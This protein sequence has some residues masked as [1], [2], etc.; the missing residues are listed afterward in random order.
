MPQR[1]HAMLQ[2]LVR[3]LGVAVT[4][5][6][7]HAAQMR[8]WVSDVVSADRAEGQG[9]A[10]ARVAR[11]LGIT[12][13]RVAEILYGRVGRVW[14]DEYDRA[15]DWHARWCAL[16]AERLAHE[17]TIYRARADALRERVG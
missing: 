7:S 4:H 15:R 8:G 2:P 11:A 3:K 16:Q 17:A 9:R 13:R 5:S 12:E 14:A 6:I 10:I 1:P